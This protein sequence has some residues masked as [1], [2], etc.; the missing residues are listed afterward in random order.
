M[1]SPVFIRKKMMTNIFLGFFFCWVSVGADAAGD[2]L[3]RRSQAT[4]PQRRRRRRERRL[5]VVDRR[6]DAGRPSDGRQR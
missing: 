6:R 5:D 1:T 2:G 4:R 3:G